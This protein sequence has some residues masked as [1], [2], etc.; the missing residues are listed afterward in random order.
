MSI[1][2][3]PNGPL[4]L[5]IIIKAKRNEVNTTFFYYT[6]QIQWEF[7]LVQVKAGN[8]SRENESRSKMFSPGSRIRLL[9]TRK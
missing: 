2:K 6:H 8:E 4:S 1:F 5:V 7:H 3:W 9:D